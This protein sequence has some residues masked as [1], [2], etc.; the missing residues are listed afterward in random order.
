MPRRRDERPKPADHPPARR[1]FTL[2]HDGRVHL[3]DLPPTGERRRRT[4]R[5]KC[6]KNGQGKYHSAI[7]RLSSLLEQYPGFPGSDEA[8]YLLGQSYGREESIEKAQAAFA[9]LLNE[10]PKS[11]YASSAKRALAKW[12]KRGG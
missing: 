2:L 8:L 10:H 3:V 11:R 7:T 4:W 9:R 1:R 6:R 12:R 5:R